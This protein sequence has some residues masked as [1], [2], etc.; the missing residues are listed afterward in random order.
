MTNSI[1][2]A[3]AAAL[4]VLDSQGPLDLHATAL[5]LAAVPGVTDVTPDA[6]AFRDHLA[7]ADANDPLRM[8]LHML[9]ARWDA[10]KDAPWIADTQ[11]G[12]LARRALALELLRVDELTAKVF[13]DRFQI[14][15]VD[16]TVIDEPWRPWYSHELRASRGFYWDHYRRHLL[17]KPGF[18]PMAVVALDAA[19][20]SVVER[21]ADPTREGRHQAKG[22]V[23]GYVQSG[24]TANFTGVIAKA[25]DAGYRLVIVL[26]GSIELLRAQ[27]QRRL[28]MELVGR[29][30]LLRNVDDSDTTAFDYEED[31]DWREGRFIDHGALPSD[32]DRPDII[33][34]TTRDFDYQS[35]RQ[36]IDSLDFPP[37]DK[38]KKLFDPANLLPSS[39]RL[40]VVKK[41]GPI[42][43]KLVKDLG[44]ITARL[45]EIP[46]L[47]IDDESDQA[48]L[49]TNDPKKW[50][51]DQESRTTINRLIGRLLTL[52]PRAQY[53]GYTATPFAN[54]FVDPSD[55]RDIF[56]KDFL[57]SLAYP[58]GY[59]GARD[60]HDFDRDPSDGPATITNS[61]TAAH[62]RFLNDDADE[63][64]DNRT[65]AEALDAFVLS[66]ALKLYR[67]DRGIGRFAHHTMLVHEAMK[68]SIHGDQAEVLRDLWR[69]GGFYS[70][71]CHHRLRG[72]YVRDFAPVSAAVYP[73][74]PSPASFDELIPYVGRAVRR[75]DETRDPVLVVNSNPALKR[76]KQQIDFDKQPVWRVLVGGNS[77]S[78]GFTVEGLTISY[79]RRV[80][81]QQDTLMQMGRWFGFRAGY[82]DLVRLYTTP[83]LHE[84][85]EAACLDEESFRDDLRKYAQPIDGERQITPE[86]VRP[87]VA[88]HLPWLKPTAA[89]KM[90]NVELTERRSP[91]I[92]VEP[93]R[94]PSDAKRTETNTL[95]FTP[96]LEAASTL[97]H[98]RGTAILQEGKEKKYVSASWD[99]R[100]FVG[101][102]DHSTFR[103]TLCE[104]DID[105]FE[106]DQRWLRKLDTTQIDNW[107][108]IFPQQVN[109]ERRRRVLGHEPISVFARQ[110]LGV[111]YYGAI[112]EVAHR[113]PVKAIRDG[114]ID[115]GD[116]AINKLVR[117]QSGSILIY[118]T[119]SLLESQPT[120]LPG[121]G[122]EIPPGMVNLAFHLLAPTS[123]VGT[124]RR[125][126]T[127]RAKDKLGRS[128]D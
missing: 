75:I 78:R 41:N 91:G 4:R 73:A 120:Q 102:V 7:E 28:D 101:E 66:G 68:T 122:A 10:D 6:D 92:A 53:V 25:I 29:Q 5:A 1:S 96:L 93:R 88:Q 106:A 110:R 26:T 59:M 112:S 20:T 42:L 51:D 98:L 103:D 125:L 123:A 115:V 18:D 77:L 32:A 8:E 54:V 16:H 2:K 49:N 17:S 86:D 113:R 84:A 85:F 80:T 47:I 89:N 95:L 39:A 52:L 27:T 118:P 99:Y 127:F 45:E 50:K 19:T 22:L 100:A 69:E 21:L 107:I 116:D 58:P 9:L 70:T 111:D 83:T 43:N 14:H 30:N 87:L 44:K 97:A 34:L 64:D 57:I 65:L 114:A 55:S 35:L 82:R 23:V 31:P 79:Y 124:D 74:A 40:I 15:L 104:L 37:R 81:K 63:D 108:V 109:I 61:N 56:P 36:G 62:V 126:V 33:R 94:H 24:K 90:H 119:V 105:D 67:Q 76:A 13:N 72:L 71:A 46:A 12:T 3:Y 128:V 60:F 11:P 117:P 48:S 38:S 121:D